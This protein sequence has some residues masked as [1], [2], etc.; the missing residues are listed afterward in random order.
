[1]RVIAG[2]YGGRKLQ[3]PRGSHTR[4]TTDRVRE[5]LF[6]MLESRVHVQGAVVADLFAGSGALGIEAFSRGAARVT[7]VDQNADAVRT[8]RGN[9]SELGIATSVEVVRSDVN[10]AIERRLTGPIDIILADPP[11]EMKGIED[12]PGL[13][14]PLLRRPGGIL[15]LE[16][17]RKVNFESV[18]GLEKTSTYGDTALSLFR[19][20]TD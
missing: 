9:L 12:L 19:P 6:S 20:P 14:L 16:H 7:F 10:A 3:A 5:A 13:L 15:V 18:R 11:Y 8:I 17:E 1:M 2:E 4:P